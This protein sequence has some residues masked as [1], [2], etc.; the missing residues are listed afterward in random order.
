LR[1]VFSFFGSWLQ[2]ADDGPMGQFWSLLKGTYW[3]LVLVGN[4]GMIHNNYE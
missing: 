4:E 2:M 1:I 3:C